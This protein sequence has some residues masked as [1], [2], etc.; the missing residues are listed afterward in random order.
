MK[1]L[2]AL[3]LITCLGPTAAQ[4]LEGTWTA[5]SEAEKTGR[6]Y[7]ALRYGRTSN[8]G[9]TYATEALAGLRADQ[10]F[11]ETST[12]VRFA[13][14]REA[15]R[16]SFDGSFRDGRGAGLFAFEPKA[17]YLDSV[18]QLGVDVSD[19]G[20]SE[21]TDERLLVL[22]LLD[23]STDYMRGMI[24]EG[25][26]VSLAEFEQTRIFDVTPAYIRA[27]REG[28]WDL[29]LDELLQS[30]IHGVT[31]EFRAEMDKLGYPLP[32]DDLVAFRIHGVTASWI[33]ELR[34]L[35]YDD[36]GADDLVST[37]IFQVTPEFIRRV[38]AA[39]YRDIPMSDLISM[40]VQG[41]D[42]ADLERR[43]GL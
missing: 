30:R 28:G 19:R 34:S 35:G 42:A 2:A 6:L 41:L 15:G 27:M 10:I 8:M 7:L 12:P 17:G 25:Y 38:F 22:A 33:G 9:T 18:R 26:R 21:D 24:A 4:A 14:E 37:R 11:A 23:V 39:G 16:V 43:R 3:A 31:P 36:L 40:R 29:S 1:R 5:A 20:R 13:L 32:F